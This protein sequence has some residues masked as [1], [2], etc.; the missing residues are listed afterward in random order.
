[1]CNWNT[2][3]ED[4]QMLN[5]CVF[6]LSSYLLH[7]RVL[8]SMPWNEIGWNDYYF[9]YHFS[10]EIIFAFISVFAGGFFLQEMPNVPKFL[11][12]DKL[13]KQS[14]TCTCIHALAERHASDVATSVTIMENKRFFINFMRAIF[15]SWEH[16]N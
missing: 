3:S 15:Y 16:F 12:N 4:P 11:Q 1:M 9:F 10:C 2:L 14:S 5:V 13:C 7:L 6:F 8:R